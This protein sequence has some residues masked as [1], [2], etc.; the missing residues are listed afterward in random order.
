VRRAAAVLVALAASTATVAVGP[1]GS[2]EAA[3]PARMTA[4]CPGRLLEKTSGG[5]LTEELIHHGA[6]PETEVVRLCSAVG[7][8]RYTFPE[9]PEGY[10]Y[11]FLFTGLTFSA[12]RVASLAWAWGSGEAPELWVIN[13]AAGKVL[14]KKVLPRDVANQETI[15]V[16]KIVVRPTGSVAWTQLSPSGACAVIEHTGRGTKVLN[17]TRK[18]E[19][20]SLRLTGTKLSWREEGHERT[21]ALH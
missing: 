13:L 9:G 16:G 5:S 12:G 1:A 21:A 17:P 10:G 14:F 15:L 8:H 19:P 3:I 20:A 11:S 7:G 2:S 18:A 6:G 4:A